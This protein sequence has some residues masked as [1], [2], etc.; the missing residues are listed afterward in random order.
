MNKKQMQSYLNKYID[1]HTTNIKIN[2]KLCKFAP[3]LS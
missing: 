1:N 3:F 2:D